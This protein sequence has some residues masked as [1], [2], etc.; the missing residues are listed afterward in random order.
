[1]TEALRR[2]GEWAEIFSGDA[3]IA[4]AILDRLLH[5]SHTISIRGESYRLR[6]KRRAGIIETT[7]SKPPNKT[8][9]GWVRSRPS[10]RGQFQT[11]P[12]RRHDTPG[13]EQD[14]GARRVPHR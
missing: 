6:D 13:V 1:M 3:V 12:D 9:G 4:T 5:H 10:Q 2:H 14:H 8:K 11:L 7:E